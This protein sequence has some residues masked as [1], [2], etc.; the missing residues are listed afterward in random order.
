MRRSSIKLEHV[1]PISLLDVSN[2]VELT[3]LQRQKTQFVSKEKIPRK[4]ASFNFSKH[5]LQ[6]LKAQELHHIP[7]YTVFQNLN[8]ESVSS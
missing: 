7:N 6:I 3:E 4:L 5:P 2:K 8:G 1:D